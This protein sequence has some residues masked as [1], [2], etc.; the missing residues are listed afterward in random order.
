MHGL[1]QG[2][3]SDIIFL[4]E[5]G[6]GGSFTPSS[7]LPAKVF[8]KII[9][10]G[11]QRLQPLFDCLL[12][13]VVNGKSPEPKFPKITSRWRQATGQ[14]AIGPGIDSYTLLLIFLVQYKGQQGRVINTSESVKWP[15]G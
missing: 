8:H 11:H 15:S 9:T 1:S 3:G 12:T 14:P 10:S 5:S 6:D 2:F 7:S 4:A 13:I